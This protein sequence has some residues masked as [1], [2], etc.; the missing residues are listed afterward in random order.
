[1]NS[2]KCTKCNIIKDLN[3]FHKSKNKADGHVFECKECANKRANEYILKNR[4]KVN[5]R[6]RQRRKIFKETAP[7]E[8]KRK[9]LEKEQE[10][11]RYRMR[12][13]INYR[14]RRNL[15]SRFHGALKRNMK[16]GSAVELLGCSIDDLKLHLEKQFKEGMSWDNYGKWEIDHIMPLYQCDMNDIEQLKIYWN[17]NNLRPLWK[18]ENQQRAKK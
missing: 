3:E 16:K 7:P 8:I 4:E 1:M 2:K 18:I 15:R 5:E 10:Y 17:F 14:L 11:Y 13:D 9:M 12:T 6:K